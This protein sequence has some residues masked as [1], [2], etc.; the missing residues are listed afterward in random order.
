MQE[1]TLN[2]TTYRPLFPGLFRPHTDQEFEGLR[3]SIRRN[4]GIQ[5]HV[6]VD[7]HGNVI[8]GWTRLT[9]AHEEGINEV[10][11]R[12]LTD[13]TDE[14]KY[15]LALSLNIDRRQLSQAQ[16]EAA[17]AKL[18]DM[19]L[20]T[21]D[22]AAKFNVSHTTVRRDLEAIKDREA[23]GGTRVPPGPSPAG[24]SSPTGDDVDGTTADP[25]TQASEPA[26]AAGP[27]PELKVRGRDGK[28][29]PARKGTAAK[30]SA[31][32]PQR[33]RD[34]NCDF[35]GRDV[36]ERLRAL[37][38]AAEKVRVLLH[39]SKNLGRL[40]YTLKDVGK[41]PG[42]RPL[43]ITDTIDALRA[44]ARDARARLP[45][46]VCCSCWN[47]EEKLAGCQVCGGL[48]WLTAGDL[49]QL[50]KEIR[51]QFDTKRLTVRQAVKD[52]S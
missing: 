13:L 36:P 33:R 34:P 31:G 8:D 49:D 17:V 15:D 39:D 5:V 19:G 41:T 23:A 50:P 35:F 32:K 7:E 46:S 25:A 48:G 11:I 26:P 4:K 18:R 24:A 21:R 6:I 51:K 3:D 14:Q 42:G 1:I 27:L 38:A 2:G 45:A 40:I 28:S 47:K 20:S 9:I 52:A 10:P 16:R 37:F 29:Y 22:I 43:R 44:A 12:V 30:G